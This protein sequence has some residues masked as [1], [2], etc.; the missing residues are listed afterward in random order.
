MN[1]SLAAHEPGSGDRRRRCLTTVARMTDKPKRGRPAKRTMPELIP[2][3]TTP[4]KTKDE[5]RYLRDGED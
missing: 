3:N 1:A 2:D 4:P 5:W